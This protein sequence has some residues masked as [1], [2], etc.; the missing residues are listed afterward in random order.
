MGDLFLG[1]QPLEEYHKSYEHSF[2][3]H[4]YRQNCT[5]KFMGDYENTGVCILTF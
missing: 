5:H 2:L 4:I 1:H 3:M